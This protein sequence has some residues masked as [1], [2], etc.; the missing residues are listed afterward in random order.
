MGKN[1]LFTGKTPEEAIEK[2]LKEIK[3]SKTMSILK[4]SKCCSA[5]MDWSDICSSCLE[6]SEPEEEVQLPNEEE[7]RKLTNKNV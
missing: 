5:L 4:N 1:K 7:N 6:H 3:N 2:L